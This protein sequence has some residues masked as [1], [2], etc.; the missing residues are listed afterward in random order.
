MKWETETV[1]EAIAAINTLVRHEVI[2]KELRNDLITVLSEV[3]A[4]SVFDMVSIL[5]GRIEV[6]DAIHK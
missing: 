6:L 3:S 2:G 4:W 5:E 1:I